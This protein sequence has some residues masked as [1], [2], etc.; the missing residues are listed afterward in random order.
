MSGT[1]LS[2]HTRNGSIWRTFCMQGEFCTVLTTK[3]PSRENFV[4]NARQRSSEPTQQHTR[5]HRCE[6]RRIIQRARAGFEARGLVQTNFAHNFPRSLFKTLRKRCNSND[7]NSISKQVAGE[8]RAKL[9]GPSNTSAQPAPQVWRAPEHP[10][11]LAAVPVGGGGAWPGF[12]TTRRAHQHTMHH[13]CG[14]RRR[15]R[16]ARAGFEIDHSEPLGSRVAFRAGGR[17]R[18][19]PEHQRC[20]VQKT[21]TPGYAKGAGTEVPAPH[22]AIASSRLRP[23]DRQSWRRRRIH[24]NMPPTTA[25]PR[26]APPIRPS[27]PVRARR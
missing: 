19:R 15:V 22:S 4:P 23:I 6:V 7:T 8:L 9:L 5:P 20:H 14:G 10:E 27:K 16:R 26:P 13:W 11:G 21:R 2:P 24:R 12:E 18:R 25:A 1:K 17:A 3:K